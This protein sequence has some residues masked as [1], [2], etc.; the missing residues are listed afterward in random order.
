MATDRMRLPPQ[1]GEEID[2][3]QQVKFLWRRRWYEGY[4]GDTIAS[5]LAASEVAVFSRSFKYHRPRGILTADQHDP[6][7]FVQVGEEP[8][9]RAGHRLVE[10]GMQVRPQNAWPSLSFDM[11]AAIRPFSRFLSPGF[12][13]KTFISPRSLVR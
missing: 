13:Y 6:N 11:K 5:A 8:N 3:T 10:A 4:A 9:V 2:R 12:Y 7:L 1:P